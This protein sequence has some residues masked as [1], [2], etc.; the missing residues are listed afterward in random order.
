MIRADV[1]EDWEA[2]MISF[3]NGLN[4]E[5]AYVVELLM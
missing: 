2:T 3:L 1:E 4:Q 5:I